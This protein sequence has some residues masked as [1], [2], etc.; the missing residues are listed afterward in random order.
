[1]RTRPRRETRGVSRSKCAD[2]ITALVPV[3]WA[4]SI[5]ISET[6]DASDYYDGFGTGELVVG[7]RA[8]Q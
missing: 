4:V 7:I 3:S 1:M 8:Y 6:V 5:I 2:L